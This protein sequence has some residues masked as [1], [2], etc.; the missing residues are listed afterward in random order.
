[1]SRGLRTLGEFITLYSYVDNDNPNISSSIF[2]TNDKEKSLRPLCAISG[3]FVEQDR[4][5][6]LCFH[7]CRGAAPL[8][9]KGQGPGRGV[10][11]SGGEGEGVWQGQDGPP[12]ATLD[13]GWSVVL[14]SAATA[15]PR[16]QRRAQGLGDASCPASGCD[17]LPWPA[18]GPKSP[19]PG[20]G[21]GSYLLSIA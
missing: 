16:S 1:M 21:S 18:L 7:H 12:E 5:L 4:A 6:L 8:K 15:S 20:W 10:W 19:L 9:A 14:V 2:L 11:A 13:A 3:C 17:V